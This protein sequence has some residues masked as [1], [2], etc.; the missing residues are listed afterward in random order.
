[1]FD[2]VSTGSWTKLA[3]LTEHKPSN[4]LT[5]RPRRRTYIR[6]TDVG[7]DWAVGREFVVTSPNSP[8]HNQVVAVDE[9]RHLKDAGYTHI[10]IHYNTNTPH[11][12]MKL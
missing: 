4:V 2:F 12:E 11:L 1:M 5:L 6:Q 10:H 8:Y 7:Y 9:T 3:S